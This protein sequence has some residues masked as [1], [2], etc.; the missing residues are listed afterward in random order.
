MH[1]VI[2]TLYNGFLSIWFDGFHRCHPHW[3]AWD[4]FSHQQN[5][6][7]EELVYKMAPGQEM[8]E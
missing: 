3:I 6:F 5:T 8:G 1:L 2:D 7:M 4:T